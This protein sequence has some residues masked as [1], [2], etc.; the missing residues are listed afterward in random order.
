MKLKLNKALFVAIVF[1]LLLTCSRSGSFCYAADYANGNILIGNDGCKYKLSGYYDGYCYNEI[2]W[3]IGNVKNQELGENQVYHFFNDNGNIKIS[4]CLEHRVST[5][6]NYEYS[7][8]NINQSK[9]M[10][11]YPYNQRQG[12]LAV[13]LYAP[14]Y[15]MQTSPV[16]GTNTDDWYWA[17]RV[18]IWE[19]QEGI[20]RSVSDGFSARKTGRFV[21]KSGAI[22]SGS[23]RNH[24]YSSLFYGN[25]VGGTPKP[26]LA[27]YRWMVNN[28]N[29]QNK[30]PSF[31]SGSRSSAKTFIL[32]SNNQAVLTDSNK[33]NVDFFTKGSD[34][35][36]SRL[37]NRYTF[38]SNLPLENGLIIVGYKVPDNTKKI[39]NVWD[40]VGAHR[41]TIMTGSILAAPMYVKLKG[42][43][44]KGNLLVH[45]TAEDD[46]VSNVKFKVTNDVD[47]SVEY[48]ITDD[49]GDARL[50]NILCGT[51]TV[52]E[53]DVPIRYVKPADVKINIENK[54]TKEVGFSNQLK[55]IDFKIIKTDYYTGSPLANAEFK[56]FDAETNQEIIISNG[57]GEEEAWVTDA[58]GEVSIKNMLKAGHEYIVREVRAPE[59]YKLD[60]VGDVSFTPTG[61]NSLDE[62][63]FKNKPYLGFRLTKTTE[64]GTELKGAEYTI[65]SKDDMNKL[66]AQ[67]TDDKGEIYVEDLE[68][69]DYV[70]IETKAPTGYLL[71]D[72]PENFTIKGEK[73]HIYE[74][75]VVDSE[76]RAFVKVKKVDSE[77]KEGLGGTKFKLFAKENIYN[78]DGLVYKKDCTIEELTT[79]ISG[80]ASSIGIPLGK[81][82]LIETKA[83]EGYIKTDE[84]FN[85]EITEENQID[86]TIENDK[87]Q[88]TEPKTGDDA[89]CLIHLIVAML[90]LSGA[91]MG[92]RFID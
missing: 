67:V 65:Y 45:K 76:Y 8:T 48:I 68:P 69:G 47:G 46:I 37:G 70:I 3:L 12:M 83:K 92:L 55:V 74:M 81:Y 27:C 73:P 40:S 21:D 54:L 72:V 62:V 52:S 61:E 28:I 49:Q 5:L 71:N 19:F 18:L 53:C 56:V 60:E 41:Q 25:N 43:T 44:P 29:S 7:S 26:A 85:F 36:V 4:Y 22:F 89:N 35:S 14:R 33:L 90:A 42:E 63:S 91:L 31:A 15:M 88:T 50:D 64:K 16:A 2:G 20:R 86:L 59:G 23:N 32:D 82:Y 79:N 66:Y 13:A 51:Y 77:N 78:G 58:S 6:G 10:K 80:E 57:S 9:Y 24:Y 87:V 30:I 39:L 38:T 17:S 34:V 1:V 84:I 11:Y 75:R